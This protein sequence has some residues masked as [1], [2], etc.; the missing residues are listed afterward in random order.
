[1]KIR[2]IITYFNTCMLVLKQIKAKYRYYKHQAF[3][4]YLVEFMP[5]N[6]MITSANLCLTFRFLLPVLLPLLHSVS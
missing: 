5:K 4:L 2:L 6:Y 3:S 1:M